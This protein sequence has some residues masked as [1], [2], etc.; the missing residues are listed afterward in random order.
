MNA[1]STVLFAAFTNFIKE[2]SLVANAR[3]VTVD[4]QEMGNDVTVDARDVVSIK[5]LDSRDAPGK[6]YAISCYGLSPVRTEIA[7]KASEIVIVFGRTG[8]QAL[9]SI[10]ENIGSPSTAPWIYA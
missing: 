3:I 6:L 2:V 1:V 9:L 4:I 8:G 10:V 5:V 7:R